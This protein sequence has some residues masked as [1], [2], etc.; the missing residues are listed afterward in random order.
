MPQNFN[1]ANC[2]PEQQQ[3]MISLLTPEYIRE[4]IA[5]YRK[6]LDPKRL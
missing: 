1:L 5:V 6:Q 3:Q 4:L 2:T